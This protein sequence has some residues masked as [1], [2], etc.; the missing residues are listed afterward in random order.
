MI[1]TYDPCDKFIRVARTRGFYPNFHC[2]S[3]VGADELAKKLGQ[4]GEG[5]I[6]TQVV[7]PPT[8]TLLLDAAEEYTKLLACYYP[9]DKPNYVGFEGYLN[10]RVMVEGLRRAG[11]DLT[12]ENFISA[13]ETIENYSLGIANPLNFN[14]Q[15]HQ[16]LEKV[17]FTQIRGGKLEL[18]T[19]PSLMETKE[20]GKSGLEK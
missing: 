9:E 2:V 12:R 15:D 7:P 6:I 16:G 18:V 5:V 1:V 19:K 10:P 3:F 20:A 8:E 11:P 4:D 17:Y 14:A 13:I